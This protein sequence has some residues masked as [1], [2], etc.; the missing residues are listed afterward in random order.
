M[1]TSYKNLNGKIKDF[2]W[3]KDDSLTKDFCQHVIDKFDNDDRKKPGVIGKEDQRVD[4]KVKD[5][6]DLNISHVDGWKTEDVIFFTA[7]GK[8]LEEYNDYLMDLNPGICS[9]PNQKF[10]KSD[11]GYKVQM[12]EPTAQYTWHHDW[13]MSGG[14]HGGDMS[15]DFVASRIFTFMWY[16]NTIPKKN[17]GYTEF[18]DG[19]KVQPKCGRIII[20]PATWTYLHRGAPTKTGRKYLT[21]GWIHAR[22]KCFQTLSPL[23]EDVEDVDD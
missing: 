10:L 23:K 19:T 15:P 1:T 18:A 8:A 5:T 9:W 17:D 20:F 2:I 11:T 13:S 6:V 7:L 12:Y 16:L 4:K 14:M 21:N 3:T 22:P